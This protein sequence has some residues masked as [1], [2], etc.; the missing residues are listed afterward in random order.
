MA[1]LETALFEESSIW[2]NYNQTNTNEAYLNTE[3]WQVHSNHKNAVKGLH[4]GPKAPANWLV[5]STI[6]PTWF[7]CLLEVQLV[8]P[9]CQNQLPFCCKTSMKPLSIPGNNQL[10]IWISN[11]LVIPRIGL[12]CNWLNVLKNNLRWFLSIA[13][14]ILTVHDFRVISAHKSVY[15]CTQWRKFLSS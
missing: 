9:V 10:I 2:Y 5:V 15:A 4:G 8:L 13:L 12:Q 1:S 7:D 11:L 14:R 3:P 6:L